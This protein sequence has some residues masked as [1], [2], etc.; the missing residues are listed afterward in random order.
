MCNLAHTVPACLTAK[1]PSITSL[2]DASAMSWKNDQGI[3]ILKW[4]ILV[5]NSLPFI[6]I[7]NGTY[8]KAVY[9]LLIAICVNYFFVLN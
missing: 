8:T 2:P 7:L 3:V 9:I 6:D 4:L 1:M 5:D